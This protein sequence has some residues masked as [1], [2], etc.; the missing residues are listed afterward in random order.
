MIELKNKRVFQSAEGLSPQKILIDFE[1]R[2]GMSNEKL[3]CSVAPAR[4]NVI[5]DHIDYNG[6]FVF[7]CAINLYLTLVIRKRSDAKISYYAKSIDEGFNFTIA[8]NFYYDTAFS[9]ANYLNGAVKFLK[10]E[11]K[12]IDSGF[13][14]LIYSNIPIGS[15]LSSSAAL[16]VAFIAALSK[17]FRFEI[18]RKEIAILG[19]RI[20]N[21]FLGLKSGIMD[22]FIISCAEENTAMLLNTAS[23]DYEYIPFRL[24]DYSLVVMNSCKP[25]SLVSSKYNERKAECELALKLLKKQAEM[26]KLQNLCDLNEDEL[27][28]LKEILFKAFEGFDL[29]YE[30]KN[31]DAIEG[32]ISA[33]RLYKRVKHCVMENLFVKKA[34]RALKEARIE[35]F[36]ALLSESH[37]SLKNNYEVSGFELDTLQELASK[38]EFCLGA[39]M[40]GAGFSGCAIA[41]VRT[42]GLEHFFAEL[43]P[44]YKQACNLNCE[45]YVCEIRGGVSVYEF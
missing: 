21:E 36:A 43:R 2:F 45:F 40:T 23:L 12:K 14:V 34:V 24:L 44:S 28:R 10:E 22:Q 42:D 39:R 33:E 32:K 15:G 16:E 37:N 1:K 20:E 18:S 8:D 27:P 25:R 29:K 35:D 19:K 9:F 26:S 38:S 11:G 17:L 4:V 3:I 31:I 7:P 41:I 5:G 6:G 30:V 13:E